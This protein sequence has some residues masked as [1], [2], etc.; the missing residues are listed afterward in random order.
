MCGR[1]AVDIHLGIVEEVFELLPESSADLDLQPTWNACPG[2]DRLIVG[3]TPVGL[4]RAK[5]ARWGLIPRWARDPAIGAKL[6]NA[7]SETAAQKPSFRDAFARQRCLIPAT[8]YYEWNPKTRV[9]HFHVVD[10][11]APFAMA[12]LWSRWVGPKGEVLDTCCVLTTAPN[13]LAAQVHDRMP[14]II[15]RP[16][17]AAW[18]AHRAP[19]DGLHALMRPFDEAR[20]ASWPVS[21]DVNKTQNDGPDL[22]R[23]HDPVVQGSLF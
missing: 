17:Y 14:V 11:G 15:D 12:G 5:M 8:G 6:S 9:P 3:S 10:E 4:R 1:F 20:M 16:D 22:I 2:T 7:R 19:K 13:P 18:L 23:R 21:R